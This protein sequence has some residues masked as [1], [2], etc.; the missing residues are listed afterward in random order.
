M[1]ANVMCTVEQT[2]KLSTMPTLPISWYCFTLLAVQAYNLSS[3]Y[4]H[5]H[6]NCTISLQKCDLPTPLALR[7]A[8]KQ[9]FYWNWV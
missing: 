6:S 5:K 7:H 3:Y 8:E 9:Q 1:T 4:L 2:V